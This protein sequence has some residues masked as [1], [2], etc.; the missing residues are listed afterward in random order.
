VDSRSV[1]KN[2]LTGETTNIKEITLRL[3]Y[4][5][6]DKGSL[7]GSF[8]LLQI[9]FNGI[10]TSALGFEMLEALKTGRNSTW[11]LGYQRSVSKKIQISIQYSGRNSESSR[12]IHA[13]GMEVRAF[14]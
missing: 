6:I 13:G 1:Q 5:Q 7:Q 14:F 4:N 2:A 8:S 10:S 11:T 12:T 3:K 9:Q